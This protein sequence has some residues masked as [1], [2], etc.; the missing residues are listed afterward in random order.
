[1]LFQLLDRQ[2]DNRQTVMGKLQLAGQL[3]QFDF[4]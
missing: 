2:V 4:P 1:M 3:L